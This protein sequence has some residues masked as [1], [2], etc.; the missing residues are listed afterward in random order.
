[1]SIDYNQ[2]KKLVLQELGTDGPGGVMSP[3]A[4]R[5]VPI[6]MPAAGTET[7]EQD[8]GDRVANEMYDIALAAR[9][10]TEELVEA[11][12]DP[13]FDAAYEHAFKASSCL[14]RVLNSLEET[15]A[16]PMPDQQVVPPAP[17]RQKYFG[18]SMGGFAGDAGSAE[19][20]IQE[21]PE[22][23][24]GFGVGTMSQSAHGQQTK[25]K[26]ADVSS[27]K[28]LQGVDN[29]ERKILLQVEDLLTDVADKVDLVKY[30]P[31]LSAFLTQFLNKIK[32][33]PDA[34]TTG[35]KT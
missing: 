26:G 31:I 13:I 14:R 11:L 8:K 23:L 21:A 22:E 20:G 16:H 24:K 2:L 17:R 25:K 1:M 30:R 6:R 27:G 18:G 32:K 7:P 35:E 9:E 19:G 34:A 28:V 33:D 3:G 12:D 4:P 5:D 29:Q 15:G 10:A